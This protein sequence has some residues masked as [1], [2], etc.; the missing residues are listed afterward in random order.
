MLFGYDYTWFIQPVI[1]FIFLGIFAVV[2]HRASSRLTSKKWLPTL[3]SLMGAGLMLTTNL[4]WI[5]QF[6]LHNNLTTA[7]ALF[8]TVAPFYLAVTENNKYWLGVTAI[9][10]IILG[11]LRIEN[12]I[13]ASLIIVLAVSSR[14]LDYKTMLYTFLPYLIIQVGWNLLVLWLKPAAFTNQ[15]SLNQLTLVTVGLIAITILLFI[16]HWR[17]F[18]EKL[19]TKSHLIIVGFLVSFIII[20]SFINPNKNYNNLWTILQNLFGHSGRWYLSWY[21]VGFP[22]LLLT[23]KIV[24]PL[25][26]LLLSVLLSY[27]AIIYIIGNLRIPYHI[28]WYDSAN[29]M[30]L[31]IFPIVVYLVVLQISA[32]HEN[33]RN[34]DKQTVETLL[35][36]Q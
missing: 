20:F 8:L 28:V 27:F 4:Y 16:S 5:S 13:V 35:T 12:V 14:K 1:S 9:F 29:R 10:L 21:L 15:L 23:D 18:K 24:F 33:N 11:L 2:L 25:K 26:R 34:S 36:Q 31:H 3:L 7:I 22:L 32:N 19:L 30:A 17:W 6:Y